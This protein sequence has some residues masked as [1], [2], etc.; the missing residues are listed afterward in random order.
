MDADHLQDIELWMKETDEKKAAYVAAVDTQE[1]KINREVK[2]HRRV[3]DK[4]LAE[5]RRPIDSA[6]AIMAFPDIPNMA[7]N[8]QPGP[9]NVATGI[10][11]EIN[12]NTFPSVVSTVSA[13]F[14]GA[15]SIRS[16][17]NIDD[18]VSGMTFMSP[19]FGTA[20]GRGTGALRGTNA[21]EDVLET[22]EDGDDEVNEIL[23]R[24]EE[25]EARLCNE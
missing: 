7:R 22:H 10:L 13:G 1:I 18:D 2:E 19:G 9:R 3:R 20:A 15:Q 21:L 14:A 4:Y 6:R 8:P 25:L 5:A 17:L 24:V 23:G 12:L 16:R 11:L